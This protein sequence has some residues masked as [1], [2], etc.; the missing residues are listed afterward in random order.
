MPSTS[1]SANLFELIPISSPAELSRAPP[2]LP[3][4]MAASVWMKDSIPFWEAPT[5]RALALM[6]PAVTVDV[7]LNGFPMASTHSPTFS[8]S[9][10]PMMI[11]GRSVASILISAR[12]VVASSPMTLALYSRLSLRV[13]IISSA[14]STT[15]LFV[16]I[17]PSSEIMTPEPAPCLLGVWIWRFWL[18]PLP[19]P[20]KS[21]KK[22]SNGS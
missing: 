21:P 5:W 20:K 12:S 14:P 19:L 17:Y 18:P 13:T 1:V 4:L 16:T 9:E 3:G 11:A 7:R 15:W 2:E 22:S 6:I 10:S 8:A